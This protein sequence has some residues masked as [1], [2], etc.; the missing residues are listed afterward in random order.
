MEKNVEFLKV[1]DEDTRSQMK[2]NSENF[3]TQ[4]ENYNG[5]IFN[6]K[7]KLFE[8]EQKNNHQESQCNNYSKNILELEM[9]ISDNASKYR[10]KEE[11]IISTYNSKIEQMKI[12]FEH[13]SKRLKN[14]IMIMTQKEGTY[15]QQI[16]LLEQKYQEA[17]QRCKMVRYEPLQR[18][19]TAIPIH[20]AK[21]RLLHSSHESYGHPQVTHRCC[22]RLWT[23]LVR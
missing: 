21:P 1:T 4:I 11:K 16:Q 22:V 7:S 20:D 13:E 17:H 8:L 6:L 18:S 10:C 9:T 23:R 15:R 12:D 5:E 3:K 14:E 19:N 2:Q